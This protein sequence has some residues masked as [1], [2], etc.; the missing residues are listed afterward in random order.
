MKEGVLAREAVRLEAA[1]LDVLKRALG[2]TSSGERAIK[3]TAD[4]WS[5]KVRC[6][7]ATSNRVETKAPIFSA[8]N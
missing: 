3:D 8:G 7:A 5:L 1:V 4:L 2:S 6:G